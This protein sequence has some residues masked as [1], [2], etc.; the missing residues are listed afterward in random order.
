V[1]HIVI[2][3]FSNS[4]IRDWPASHYGALVARL[5]SERRETIR[6]VGAPGQAIRAREIVRPF[7]ARRVIN[8]CGRLSW[9]ATVELIRSA[10]CVIGNNSGIAHLA[11]FES[12]PTLC[13][14]GGAH[15]RLEWRPIGRRVVTLS[16]AIACSPCH[17]HHAAHCPYGLACLDQITP[18]TVFEAVSRLIDHAAGEQ[19]AD[20][21]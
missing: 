19:F 4:D 18:E 12:V 15:Q 10:A 2:A 6:V 21:A 5:I 13:V 7:D 9:N 14:F 1:S 20:V 11:A 16:R 8:D 3:P 17:L